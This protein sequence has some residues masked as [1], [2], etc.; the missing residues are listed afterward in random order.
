MLQ[1]NEYIDSLLSE[2]VI[3]CAFSKNEE[4]I[5]VNDYGVVF[6]GFHIIGFSE[7]DNSRPNAHIHLNWDCYWYPEYEEKIFKKDNLKPF[8][9]IYSASKGYYGINKDKD[10][11]WVDDPA[12]A[13]LFSQQ[14]V[15]R[16]CATKFTHGV[17]DSSFIGA[18]GCSHHN[19]KLS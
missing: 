3:A 12:D 2:P 8:Y 16:I 5:V 6:Q 18:V 1:L 13:E 10:W 15:D 14:T 4:V 9:R 17:K 7:P 19:R 11:I